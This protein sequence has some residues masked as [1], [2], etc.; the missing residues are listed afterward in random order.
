M[1]VALRCAS[2][3]S[4][5]PVP[6]AASTARQHAAACAAYTSATSP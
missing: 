1:H 6:R 5:R 2:T 4:A 3:D